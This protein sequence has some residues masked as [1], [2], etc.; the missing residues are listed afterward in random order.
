MS[1]TK[2]DGLGTDGTIPA[3]DDGIAV[4]LGDGSNFNP[5]EDEESEAVPTSEAGGEPMTS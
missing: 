2:D 5:E 3:S 4:S 1:D